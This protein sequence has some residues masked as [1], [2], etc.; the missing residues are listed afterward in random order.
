M[1]FTAATAG[2]RLAP[3]PMSDH[4]TMPKA[5]AAAL[6][7]LARSRISSLAKLALSPAPAFAVG[8]RLCAPAEWKAIAAT[9]ATINIFFAW[10]GIPPP[11]VKAISGRRVWQK[12]V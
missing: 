1:V 2:K 6:R 8:L 12:V 11:H 3:A 7:V 5:S 10:V 4:R 9:A